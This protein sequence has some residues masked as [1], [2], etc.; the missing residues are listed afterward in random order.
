MYN[1]NIIKLDAIP[2]SNDF[3]KQRHYENSAKNDDLCWAG[4]QTKGRGQ[5]QNRW[6]AAAGKNLTFS[7]YKVF[8][9]FSLGQS[10]LL[11]AAVCVAV[12]EALK[13]IGLFD[14]KVKWPND[15]LSANKKI[16]GILIENSTQ[17]KSIKSSVIGIG[18]NVNQID[19]EGLPQASS[20]M[21]AS[22]KKWELEAVL[23]QLLF[24]LRL[25]FDAFE[26]GERAS[27]LAPYNALLWQRKEPSEFSRGE[28]SFL[29]TLMGVEKNGKALIELPNRE[30]HA[31][32]FNELK[33][34]YRV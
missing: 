1:F 32:S 17:S 7:I 24:R 13:E 33:M 34:N 28:H 23:K 22:G 31:Y 14:T 12:V 10:F 15:I 2:S 20:L 11:N 9:G 16:G 29:A 25:V 30:Q 4:F 26:Q 6:N 8:E 18:L 3:L 27:F 21:L 19:F 5:H